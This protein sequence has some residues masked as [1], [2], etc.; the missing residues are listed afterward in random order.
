MNN[1]S[2]D[3]RRRIRVL[4]LAPALVLAVLATNI[5]CV[6]S[7]LSAAT[8]TTLVSEDGSKGNENSSNDQIK[9]E[10]LNRVMQKITISADSNGVTH[11]L[12]E[13]DVIYKVDGKEVASIADLKAEDIASMN[14]DKRGEKPIVEITTKKKQDGKHVKIAYI[15][16][17]KKVDSIADLKAED[18]VLVNINKQGETPVMEVT[19][20]G[21]VNTFKLNANVTLEDNEDL[22]SLG[23]HI[24]YKVDG[25]Q[26]ESIAE[27]TAEEIASININKQGETPIVEVTT[28]KVQAQAVKKDLQESDIPL[29]QLQQLRPG[30]TELNNDGGTNIELRFSGVDGFSVQSAKFVIKD[31]A[32]YVCTQVSNSIT[33]DGTVHVK[34]HTDEIIGEDVKMFVVELQTTLGKVAVPILH[35]DRDK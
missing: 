17:G 9:D 33:E 23:D 27:L 34:L 4:A 35:G 13:Q 3:A 30:V 21:V 1:Q 20:K 10:Q 8:T 6:A 32:E 11:N 29:E 24:I 19:T 28:K 18:I 26:V 12:G 2:T 16:D 31:K 22:S 14:V 25:K 7:T 5:P 15:V